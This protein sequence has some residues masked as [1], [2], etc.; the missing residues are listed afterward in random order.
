MRRYEILFMSKIPI[1]IALI[2]VGGFGCYHLRALRQVQ[3]EGKVKLIAVAD[4]TIERLPEVKS[5]L[6]AAG[7]NLYLRHEDLLAA[8]SQLEAISIVAPI[9]YHFE[10]AEQCLKRGLFVYL[11]KPPVPV[12]SQL[13]ELI[14]IGGERRVAVGFQQIGS[15]WMQKLKAWRV[16]GKLGEIQNIRIA[17]CWPRPDSYYSR[18]SW[19][20]KLTLHNRPVYD[21]PATNALSH[22]LQ[23][24]TYLAAA[25]PETFE[26]PGEVHAELYRARNIES[27]DTVCLAGR[28]E[29]GCDFSAA[30][31]HST[32]KEMPFRLRIEGSEGWA[33]VSENG[34]R[35]ESSFGGEVYTQT[36]ENMM[37][38]LYDN[39]VE[40]VTGQRARPYVRLS[41]TR[42]YLQIAEGMFQSSGT[43]HD[44]PAQWVSRHTIGA[45]T[46]YEVTGMLEAV[47]ESFHEGTLFSAQDQPWA[48]A[49]PVIEE[50]PR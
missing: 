36:T 20:G 7:V 5:E 1:K 2:G 22:L 45:E 28:F 43:I 9:P 39:F 21:G 11:E 26:L 3:A 38:G 49:S 4:P 46:N 16:A 27:Y 40:F 6:L 13:E 48:V 32:A 19:A 47:E 12:L 31:T 25:E 30:L 37:H 29:S 23:N 17:A 18:A 44:I 14:R 33:E 34:K 8:E 24:M 42:G 50:A 15:Q 10:M 41:D 35:L